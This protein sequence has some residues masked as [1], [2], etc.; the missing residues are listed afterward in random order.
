M[1]EIHTC[2]FLFSFFIHTCSFFSFWF[3]L[4]KASRLV[5]LWIR[6]LNVKFVSLCDLNN[7]STLYAWAKLSFFCSQ[8]Q[9]H[10][11]NLFTWVSVHYTMCTLKQHISFELLVFDLSLMVF[12]FFRYFVKDQGFMCFCTLSPQMVNLPLMAKDS[13]WIFWTTAYFGCRYR[14]VSS[15]FLLWLHNQIHIWISRSMM[16]TDIW[17]LIAVPSTC[18]LMHGAV[19]VS[20]STF[21]ES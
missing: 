21:V 8:N 3:L 12:L 5:C 10:T 2:S 19:I 14:T 13:S 11:E 18:I 15:Q 20:M 1:I 4:L 6:K 9:R 16:K 7:I 17:N